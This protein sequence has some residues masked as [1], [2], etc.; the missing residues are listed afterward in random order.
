MS[1]YDSLMAIKAAIDPKGDKVPWGSSYGGDLCK[2]K[3]VACDPQGRVYSTYVM[4]SRPDSQPWDI[5]KAAEPLGGTMPP[6]SAFAGLPKVDEF[7]CFY[8]GL[9]GTLPA[10]YANIKTLTAV[11]ITG[12]PSSAPGADKWPKVSGSIPESWGSIKEMKYL[13]IT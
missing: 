2:W 7:A 5:S 10:D 9:S 8:C 1:Q 3:G 11:T 13:T 4:R 6:A 12:W